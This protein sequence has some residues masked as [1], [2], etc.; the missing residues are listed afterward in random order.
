HTAASPL[1]SWR[2]R[3]GRHHS[4]PT[5]AAARSAC[6]LRPAVAARCAP[7]W[8]EASLPPGLAARTGLPWPAAV[9]RPCLAARWPA[10]GSGRVRAS[11]CVQTAR[12]GLIWLLR[13]GWSGRAH[14]P[15]MASRRAA[16][17]SGR[18]QRS[19]LDSRALASGRIWPRVGQP[20]RAAARSGVR[21]ALWPDLPCAVGLGV[22]GVQ[23]TPAVARRGRFSPALRCG[24]QR[25]CAALFTAAVHWWCSFSSGKHCQCADGVT[26]SS[27]NSTLSGRCSVVLELTPK[28]SQMQIFQKQE[29]VFA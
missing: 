1:A 10:A 4:H 11:R 6:A 25:C 7:I 17:L 19:G 28:T 3:K 24:L 13:C 22:H 21:G 29:S 5:A 9:L 12:G 16:A 18:A 8:P 15:A 26:L 2:P 27:R 20:L 14:R 23:R